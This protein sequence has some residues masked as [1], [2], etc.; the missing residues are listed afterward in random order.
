[1]GYSVVELLNH[2]LELCSSSFTFGIVQASLALLLL[3]HDLLTILDV[4]A[5]L[6]S[7]LHANTIDV[8][9][10]ASLLVSI[11]RGETEITPHGVVKL[12]AGDLIY[13]LVEDREIDTIRKAVE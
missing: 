4:D 8:E 1:M 9:D 6:L 13:V 10:S 2:N 12:Q 7:L 3:N 11:Q 5:L